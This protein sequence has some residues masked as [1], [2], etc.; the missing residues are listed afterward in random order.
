MPRERDLALRT[1]LEDLEFSIMRLGLVALQQGFPPAMTSFVIRVALDARI[2][3]EL[4]LLAVRA[5]GHSRE[6]R[7]L[8]TLL[9]LVDGGKTLL[10]KPKLAPRSPMVLTAVKA[11]AKGWSAD[12]RAEVMLDLAAG[13]SDPEVRQAA[14]PNRT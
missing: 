5:L 11:L 1:A 10:G 13:S 8:S 3:E 9:S 12:P 14:R 4:R 7:A 6:P 2:I